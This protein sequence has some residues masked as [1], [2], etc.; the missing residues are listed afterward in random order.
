MRRRSNRQRWLAKLTF[1]PFS[2]HTDPLVLADERYP[3]DHAGLGFGLSRSIRLRMSANSSLAFACLNDRSNE[4]SY[5]D[6]SPIALTLRASLMN[7]ATIDL[8]TFSRNRPAFIFTAFAFLS[9]CG[10]PSTGPS[11]RIDGKPNS[12]LCRGLVRIRSG[13]AD[14]QNHRLQPRRACGVAM[15]T[16]RLA[17]RVQFRTSLP[18]GILP[19]P[20]ASNFRTPRDPRRG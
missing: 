17:P 20:G 9:S 16:L 10:S 7:A 15:C 2:R 18:V 14:M 12:R 13:S 8:E 4:P 11:S 19:R 5:R 1:G 3:V 6:S